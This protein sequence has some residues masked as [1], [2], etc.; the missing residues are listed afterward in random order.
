VTDVECASPRRK[1]SRITTKSNRVA[2]VVLFSFLLAGGAAAQLSGNYTIDPQGSGSRNYT[3]F[4]AA[5]DALK[6]GVS[7]PVVFSVASTTFK[8]GVSITS[9]IKGAS[10]VNT[11]TFTAPGSPATLVGQTIHP[12]GYRRVSSGSG[13]RSQVAGSAGWAAGSNTVRPTPAD[14]LR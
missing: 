12:A 3:S 8:E 9:A 10:A 2:L 5:T 11:V 7:G 6:A 4:K 14:R 13:R 1:G